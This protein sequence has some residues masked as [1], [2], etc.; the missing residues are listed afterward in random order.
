MLCRLHSASSMPKKLVHRSLLNLLHQ[1]SPS[2]RLEPVLN[3]SVL[4]LTVCVSLLQTPIPMVH[5]H[6]CLGS[7]STLD[8][9]LA[10][11]HEHD[12][13]RDEECHWHF[14][15]PSDLKGDGERPKDSSPDEVATVSLA[16]SGIG[17]G[18]SDSPNFF[19]PTRLSPACITAACGR[20]SRIDRIDFTTGNLRPSV[21][22][23]ALLCVI[24]C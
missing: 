19:F 13:E 9:H 8:E 16:F 1:A 20:Q 5:H 12:V 17:I 14:L 4:A 7:E 3:R 22:A 23:C 6:G 2:S 21:R 11:H 15:L 18:T 10:Q 24:R